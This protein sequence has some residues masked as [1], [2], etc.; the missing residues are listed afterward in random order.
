MA[1]GPGQELAETLLRE[2]SEEET[3]ILYRWSSKL[4]GGH[5]R[6][7][8]TGFLGA[9][10]LCNYSMVALSNAAR[11]IADGEVSWKGI[12]SD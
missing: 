2:L 11:A 9:K 12:K 1:M 5:D 3:D 4:S 6:Q 7:F 8:I 10:F